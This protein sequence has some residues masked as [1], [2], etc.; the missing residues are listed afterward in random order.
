VQLQINETNNTS[1]IKCTDVNLTIGDNLIL[2]SL[3][4]ELNH[5]NDLIIMGP[6]GAGKTMLLT[7][8]SGNM[9]PNK[10]I[11]EVYGQRFIGDD[12]VKLK[13]Q[14][15]LVSPSMFGDYD[16]DSKVKQIVM[17]GLFGSIG[18][19][20]D[21]TKNNSK[22]VREYINRVISE[23]YGGYELSYDYLKKVNMLEYADQSFAELS[24]GQKVRV[25]IAR[26]LIVKPSLLILDEPTTGLDIKMRSEFIELV[27]NLGDTIDI[28][29]V[30]H[31]I[32]E[33]QPF[34]SHVLLLKDGKIFKFGKK[35]SVLNTKI[36]SQLFDRDISLTIKEDKYAVLF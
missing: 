8:L 20:N 11:I 36:I 3:N 13:K 34:F 22:V 21:P 14:I 19:C 27:N 25:L 6:N 26:A 30:T 32:E 29:Y 17:S 35:E 28:I 9:Q 7:L 16:Q 15:G 5:G 31:Y 18:V 33:I 23:K 1:I 10:G 2:E 4:F 24:Y 12:S